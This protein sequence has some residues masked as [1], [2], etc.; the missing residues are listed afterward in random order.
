MSAERT[1]GG[2]TCLLTGATAGI[3][4]ETARGLARLGARLVLVARDPQRG[5]ATAEWVKHESGNPDV[6]VLIA[7]LSSQAAIRRLAAEFLEQHDRLH[8]LI[9]NAGAIY[10]KREVTAD[11]IER[12]LATNHLAYFLLTNLLVPALQAGAPSRVVNVASD[13]HRR[14]RIDFGDLQFERGYSG[15]RAY[16]RS[17]LCN[18]LF[19]YELSRRL[20]GGGVTANCLHP[21]V[22][23]TGWG[24]NDA[25]LL[26]VLVRLGAPL[27]GRPERGARTSIFLAADAGVAGVS[28]RYFERCRER[29]SSRA[30]RDRETARRLWEESAR[31]TGLAQGAGAP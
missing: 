6:S 26:G 17:K 25:G 23:A 8:V 21:G 2:R 9:N 27:L 3:G 31:L 22:I 14:G 16:A 12:T 15:Y 28:G 7:D 13:S 18:V 5:A 1:L 4:K 20:E 24:R 19:T 10:T 29:P 11:G 30:S